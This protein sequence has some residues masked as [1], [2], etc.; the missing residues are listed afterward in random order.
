MHAVI[1]AQLSEFSSRNHAERLTETEYFE[2]FSIHAVENGLLTQNLNPFDAHLKGVEFGL[3]GVAITVQGELCRTTDDAQAALATGRNHIAEFHF[4]QSKT[5]EAVEYGDV[6]KFLDAVY[7][8][9]TLGSLARSPQI[10]DLREAK[11]LIYSSVS[12]TNPTLRC[13]YCTTGTG[14]V[15]EPIQKLIEASKDRLDALSLFSTIDVQVFGA[16]N[17]QGGYRAATNSISCTIEFTKAITLPVHE[18][19]QEGFIGFIAAPELVKLATLET[20]AGEPR[21]VNRAV[22]YDNIRDFNPTSE[23]NQSILAEISAGN[24]KSFI[25]KNNGVT[26]IAREVVRTRDTFKI[27]DYQI[28]NGCQTT[29]ILFLAG[30][31]AKD[32]SVPFRLIVSSDSD[33]IASIIVG[34]NKQN[35]VKEDQ[36]WA[37]SPFMKDLE[38]YCRAQ[39]PDDAIFIERRENQYRELQVERTRIFKPGDLMK[40]IAA[41][42]LWQPNRA[43]RDYRG[44]RKEFATKVFQPSHNVELYHLAALA[45]YRF[46]FYV[47]NNRIDRSRGIYKF[48]TLYALVRGILNDKDLLTSERKKQTSAIKAMVEVVSDETKFLSLIER[49]AAT[50]DGLISAAGLSTRE[51][52]RDYIRAESVVELFSNNHFKSSL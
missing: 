35:E 17:L 51:Q 7:D 13:F 25:F 16:K 3:D 9:F 6:S 30:D 1:K 14:Q 10:S 31:K 22:F 23:I 20:D 41:M 42:Y 18:S 40:A 11:D 24:H 50:L 27:E 15:S 44:I 45:S 39:K 4:F 49:V 36:F 34:T 28:V 47:R 38:E 37:L 12:K 32:I 2:V 46:D 33:F 52:I 5:S 43:A 8:F 21:A 26:V 19:V 29:N 48:Y